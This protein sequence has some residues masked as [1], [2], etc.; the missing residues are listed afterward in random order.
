MNS[1]PSPFGI[2]NLEPPLDLVARPEDCAVKVS[3]AETP[4]LIADFR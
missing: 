3:T 2:Y 1:D 4:R